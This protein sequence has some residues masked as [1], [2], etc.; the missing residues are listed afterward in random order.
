MIYKHFMD[1]LL[2]AIYKYTLSKKYDILPN[3]HRNNSQKP[4]SFQERVQD[5]LFGLVPV[6]KS[7]TSVYKSK[8]NTE[9]HF[10]KKYFSLFF[11]CGT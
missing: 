6:D 4:R 9:Q 7:Y 3:R 1:K 5:F 10:L 11:K 8:I 2:Q